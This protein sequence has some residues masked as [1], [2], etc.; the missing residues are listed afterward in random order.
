MERLCFEFTVLPSSDGKSNIF[1]I[2]SIAVNEDKVYAIPEEFQSVGYHKDLM[3]TAAYTKV[4]NSIKKRYQTRKIW[5][6]MTEELKKNYMDEDGNLQF[7][8]QYLEEMDQKQKETAQNSETRLL[9]K[10]FEKLGENTQEIKEQS[11]KHIAERFVIEKFTSRHSNAIQWM[12]T[13]EKECLRFNVIKDEKKIEVLRLFLDKTCIDW[14]SSMMIQLT[15][16]SEWSIWKNKF[17]ATFT[18]KGWSQIT[19]ALSFKYIDGLL[20]D[21]AIKK[22]KLLLEMRN[23][24]DT[25]TLIDLIAA[26]LPEFILTKI[27]REMLKDTVDLFNEVR[28]YEHMVNKRSNSVYKRYGNPR[29]SNRNEDR[30]PC[31][32]CEKLYKGVRYHPESACWFKTDDGDDNKIKKNVIRHVNNSVI[33]AELNETETKN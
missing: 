26:G 6:T 22:E 33:E 8:D 24:I 10:I 16:D 14:Y 9:E 23:S 5:I 31:K 19:Y 27:D 20:V 7:G 2:I 21:Y 32:T 3:K 25:G 18:N 28:K 17:C 12:D 11:L 30:K 4:K 13:F 15:M 29:G 1:C